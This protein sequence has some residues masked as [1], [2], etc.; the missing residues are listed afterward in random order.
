MLKL[1]LGTF[2]ETMSNFEVKFTDA[3][4]KNDDARQAKAIVVMESHL[5]DF[6]MEWMEAGTLQEIRGLVYAD[7]EESTLS[8]ILYQS[9]LEEMSPVASGSPVDRAAHFTG[10]LL[11]RCDAVL[12][13]LDVVETDLVKASDNLGN[14]NNIDPL[15]PEPEP[16]PE[17]EANTASE[18]SESEPGVVASSTSA[19]S[20]IVG[21]GTVVS[22][23][24]HANASSI[25]D[26]STDDDSTGDLDDS[27]ERSAAHRRELQQ[28]ITGEDM[29]GPD[30]DLANCAMARYG[31]T[32]SN[33]P[34][35]QPAIPAP[36]AAAGRLHRM[37][38]P[39]RIGRAIASPA[40]AVVAAARNRSVFNNNRRA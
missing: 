29:S 14:V 32:G 28:A 16:E 25:H 26:D 37:T 5:E 1:E 33:A 13:D 2:H 11:E 34:P 3:V 22:Y 23:L 27:A 36:A 9:P 35:S 4:G 21:A 20:V 10:D 19:T 6:A 39:S 17:P 12:L 31:L 7:E 38:S 24:S 8:S 30:R 18:S 15:E 40:K